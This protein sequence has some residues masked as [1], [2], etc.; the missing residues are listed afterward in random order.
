MKKTALILICIVIFN[1]NCSAQSETIKNTIEEMAKQNNLKI[2][3]NNKTNSYEI[4]FPESGLVFI[5]IEEFGFKS[6]KFVTAKAYYFYNTKEIVQNFKLLKYFFLDN[7]K[8]KLGSW[9]IQDLD[10]VYAITMESAIPINI[11]SQ[12]LFEAIKFLDSRV[13]KM[14]KELKEMGVPEDPDE[15]N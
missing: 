14:R 11:S 10:T 5:S 12:D 7:K 8:Y 13:H 2:E 1:M 4:D 15:V 6:T 3:F 9:K